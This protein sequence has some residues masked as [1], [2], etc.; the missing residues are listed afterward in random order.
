MK[1]SKFILP[2]ASIS[3]AAAAGGQNCQKLN[4]TVT[5]I[6][7]Q[8]DTPTGVNVSLCNE[9]YT[10][11]RCPGSKGVVSSP[12]EDGDG[13]KGSYNIADTF[14]ALTLPDR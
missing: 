6:T 10:P 11:P 3:G 7:F 2:L 8:V 1:T 9:L 4:I 12:I 13:N 5:N 14:S